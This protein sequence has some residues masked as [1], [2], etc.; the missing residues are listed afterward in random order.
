MKK[1][2]SETLRQRER[3]IVSKMTFFIYFTECEWSVYVLVCVCVGV[4]VCMYVCMYACM[5]VCLC[6][7]VDAERV[8]NSEYESLS[9]W[10]W[11]S[12][13]VSEAERMRER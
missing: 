3:Q 4:C 11:V 2:M 9:G 5:H 10:E 8:S 12:E 6:L 1:K 13:W 7:V